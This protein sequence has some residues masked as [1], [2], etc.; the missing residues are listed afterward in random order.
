MKNIL[1]LANARSIRPSWRELIDSC[2]RARSHRP[3]RTI[4][5]LFVASRPLPAS[6]KAV[7]MSYFSF[8]PHL[9]ERRRA[10][11]LGTLAIGFWPCRS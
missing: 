6:A 4:A 3:Q 9:S 10:W 7:F 5:I 11:L 8:K 1:N 2:Q